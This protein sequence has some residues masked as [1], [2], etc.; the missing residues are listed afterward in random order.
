MENT[1]LAVIGDQHIKKRI[2]SQGRELFALVEALGKPAIWL[3]DLFDTK[4]IINGRC[5][6]AAIEY[7]SNSQLIHYLVV[8]NHD[9]FNLDCDDHAL[10]ALALLKNVVVI[11]KPHLINDNVVAFP[12][13]HDRA[14]LEAAIAQFARPDRTLFGHLEVDQFDFGNGHI[15]TSGISLTAL[16]GFKRVISGH[17]HKFQEQGNLTFLGTPYTQSQGEANQVKYIGLYNVQRDELKKAETDFPKH[18]TLEVDC[19]NVVAEKPYP[20][21]LMVPG[22]ER[23]LYRV[24]LTGTQAN[25]DKFP[26]ELYEGKGAQI[27]W[28]A[29]PA[30]FAENSIVLSETLSN[31]Q[32]F[33]QWAGGVKKMEKETLD[34]GLSILEACK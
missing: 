7:F 22:W 13:I 26:K 12:Y 28:L 4:E 10:K 8:G 16:S 23:H 2:L 6:N 15:C 17:F 24:I 31:E 20:V 9:Y 14:K 25:I 33:I 5:L 32:Q 30:D 11:D 3:G 29:R 18:I 21:I 19:D 27:K 34:L 1:D